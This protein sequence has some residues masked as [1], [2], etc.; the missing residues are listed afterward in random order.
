TR[1]HISGAEPQS[2][3]PAK[4]SSPV[5]RCQARMPSPAAIAPHAISR[6][7]AHN[8]AASRYVLSLMRAGVAHTPGFTGGAL[9][10]P[11]DD[12]TRAPSSVMVLADS[13][14]VSI[15]VDPSWLYQAARGCDG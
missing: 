6:S 7:T 12:A 8:I 13:R 10:R 15:T 3:R 1:I 2:C 4:N 14:A 9:P 11:F 5:P